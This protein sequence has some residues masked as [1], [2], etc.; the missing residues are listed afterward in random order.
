MDRHRADRLRVPMV[1]VRRSRC[2]RCVDCTRIANASNASYTLRQADAGFRIRSQ[3]IGRNAEGQDTAT[4][5]PTAVVTAARPVNLT[6]PSISGTARVG[7]T[8]EANRGQWAGDQP[9]TCSY[10]WLRCNDKG[11]NCS[12][13]QGENDTSYQVREADGGRTIRVV[14]SRATTVAR[15][16]PSRTPPAWSGRTSRRRRAVDSRERAEGLGDRLVV[17][18]VSSRRIP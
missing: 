18:S 11:D 12:E 1:P 5:N 16:R 10:V 8:L 17:A 7:S 3:V 4:S 13:I 6:E 9:I 2:G 14:S 15:P